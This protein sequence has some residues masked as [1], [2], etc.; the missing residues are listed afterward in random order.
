MV[1]ED[2]KKD[3]TLNET[4]K[5]MEQLNLDLKNK[6]PLLLLSLRREDSSFVEQG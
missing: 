3:E 1:L 6:V 4:I 5:L 2:M